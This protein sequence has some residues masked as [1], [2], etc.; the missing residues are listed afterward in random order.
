MIQ[1]FAATPDLSDEAIRKGSGKTWAE[2]VELLDAWGAAEKPHQE[3]A[4]YVYD[5]GVDGWWAQGVAVGYERIKGLRDHGQRR[6]GRF[7]GS[8]SKTFAVHVERLFT[9]WTDESERNRWLEP[10]TVTMRT[11]QDHRSARFDLAGGGILALWFTDKGLEKS[12]VAV[13]RA[14]LPSKEAADHF[15]ETWKA[16]LAELSRYLKS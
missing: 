14:G 15:R 8:A 13:Q 2:W 16:H 11:A 12:S 3:I 7:V 5:L 6:D 1:T 10:G 4:R 9:A